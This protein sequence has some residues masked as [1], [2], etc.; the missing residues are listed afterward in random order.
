M[1]N[2]LYT[3]TVCFVQKNHLPVK[4][5]RTGTSSSH[6]QVIAAE[7]FLCSVERSVQLAFVV[8]WYD[9]V[10]NVVHPFPVLLAH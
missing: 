5:G 10:Q 6:P 3:N 8:Q 7:L 4:F 2:L 1:N 9:L